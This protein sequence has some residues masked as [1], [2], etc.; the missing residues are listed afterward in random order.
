MLLSDVRYWSGLPQSTEIGPDVAYCATRSATPCAR[1]DR[2]IGI[3]SILTYYVWCY[4]ATRGELSEA[5]ELFISAPSVLNMCTVCCH[6][7]CTGYDVCR[8]ICT[9]RCIVSTGY[10]VCHV[11]CTGYYA[12]ICTAI[13]LGTATSDS[14]VLRT[15]YAM[16]GT[17]T[18][19]AASRTQS[20]Y[21]KPR[22]APLSA[23]GL[24]TLCPVLR[25]ATAISA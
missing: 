22:S 6:L 20:S 24:D 25:Y 23:Y 10:Y 12:G 11:I 9:V 14:M 21:G 3:L 2:V 8:I 19:Y 4:A 7:Y 18:G 1:T 15:R 13:V 16:S 5:F 17:K